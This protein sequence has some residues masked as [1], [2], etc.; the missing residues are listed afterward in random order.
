MGDDIG[1]MEE[2]SKTQKKRKG[3]VRS[4]F[5]FRFLRIPILCK[6]ASGQSSVVS[7]FIFNFLLSGGRGDWA[8]Q[9]MANGGVFLLLL[10]VLPFSSSSL[11]MHEGV[12]PER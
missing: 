12:E 8:G 1:E 3:R 2:K 10:H 11:A 4:W 7:V 6:R 9:L 5:C